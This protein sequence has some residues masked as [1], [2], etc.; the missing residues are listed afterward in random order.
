V[1]T[2]INYSVLSPD[3]LDTGMQSIDLAFKRRQA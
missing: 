1:F 3:F 2:G